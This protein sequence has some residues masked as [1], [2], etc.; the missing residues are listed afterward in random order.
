MI[1]KQK[2]IRLHGDALRELNDAI[3]ERD[4]GRCIICGRYVEPGTKF[5][6]VLQASYKTDEI[7][8]GVL[9][10]PECHHRAHFVDVRNIKQKCLAY[11]ERKYGELIR[12][13]KRWCGL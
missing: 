2:R 1:A 13:V 12:N 8:Y 4:G 7:E 9:L 5:H 11:L 10:C 6:H 3:Y